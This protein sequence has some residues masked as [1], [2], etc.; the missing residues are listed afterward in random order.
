MSRSKR[1][2]S[3]SIDSVIWHRVCAIYE[4]GNIGPKLGARSPSHLVEKVLIAFI[5]RHDAHYAD[6]VARMAGFE[7][8]MMGFE[9][10]NIKNAS[11]GDLL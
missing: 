3:V 10:G 11:K 2:A 8:E 1:K 5:V 4:K 6:I 7:K 9:N